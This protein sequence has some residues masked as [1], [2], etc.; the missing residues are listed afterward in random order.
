MRRVRALGGRRRLVLKACV[1]LS[2]AAIE[3]VASK[4]SGLVELSLNKLP[5]LSDASLVAL[6]RHC[7]DE[8]TALDISWCRGLTDHGVGAL[9]DAAE[10]LETLTLWGCTNLTKNFFDGHSRDGLRIVGRCIG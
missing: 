4:C 8:L 10:R 1:Q 7:T 6:K 9:V 5:A 3:A 2:D